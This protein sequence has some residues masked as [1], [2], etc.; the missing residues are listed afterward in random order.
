VLVVDLIHGVIIDEWRFFDRPNGITVDTHGN[1]FV[2]EF[3][4]NQVIMLS[5]FGEQLTSWGSEGTGSGEFDRPF[6]VAVD[7]TGTVYVTDMGNQRVQLFAPVQS[8]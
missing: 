4:L 8:P 7:S 1:V 5:P 6:D 2:T 3:R